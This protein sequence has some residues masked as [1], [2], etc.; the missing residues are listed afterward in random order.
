MAP[1]VSKK[2]NESLMWILHVLRGGDCGKGEKNKKKTGWN[3][4]KSNESLT[5]LLHVLLGSD[6]VGE[7][8]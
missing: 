6:C 2:S 3:T 8:T 7:R 1:L 4:K 5:W